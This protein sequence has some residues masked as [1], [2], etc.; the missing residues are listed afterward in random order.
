MADEQNQ[1]IKTENTAH[2]EQ[3][4]ERTPAQAPPAPPVGPEN[5]T[6]QLQEAQKTAETLRD[7][8]LRKAAEFENYKRRTE[9]DFAA[10]IKSANENLLFALLPVVDDLARSLKA[11]KE[12]KDY[13]AF[14]R[15]AELIQAKLS[16]ALESFGLSPFVSVGKQFD[17][18]YHDAL[19][20][21]P[22]ADVPS[23]TVIEEVEKGYALNEKVLRHAKVIV[24]STPHP[25][26]L[27]EDQDSKPTNDGSNG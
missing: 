1:N 4:D 27:P 7:Q 19:L 3:P 14:Y 20:Q 22:R 9:N 16:K 10:L 5:L 11:G 15:G 2:G 24:S 21:I 17:V 26:P 12:Q 6:A 8:L 25:S 13:D 23:H 18:A